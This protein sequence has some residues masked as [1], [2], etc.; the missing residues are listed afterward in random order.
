M[1]AKKCKAQRDFK[2]K[3]VVFS[4]QLQLLHCALESRDLR[5][6]DRLS[7]FQVPQEIMLSMLGPVDRVILVILHFAQDE[8][9]RSVGRS[10]M[11]T[12]FAKRRAAFGV[13]EAF[14]L[15]L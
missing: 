9:Y 1:H 3:A 7:G 2:E 11:G 5:K 15:R 8:F 10:K 12:A 6:L 13:P 4:F 14:L